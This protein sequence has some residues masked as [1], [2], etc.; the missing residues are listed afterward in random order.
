M[1]ADAPTGVANICYHAGVPE[2]VPMF[3]VAGLTLISDKPF[4]KFNRIATE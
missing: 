2:S 3:R 1:A 4:V